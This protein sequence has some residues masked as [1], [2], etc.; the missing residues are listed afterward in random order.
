MNRT[1]IALIAALVGATS[2]LAFAA[3]P[4]S[5]A[6]RKERMDQAYQDSR[7]A[8]PGPAA[9]AESS[10]KRGAARTGSA[11]KTGAQK[12]GRAVGT[13][14]RKTGEVIGRGGEKLQE[15]STPKP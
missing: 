1:R 2:T 10:I 13:G 5:E 8:Q 11:V 9:R 6:A 15:A 4:G 7:N 3:E 14:V 12:A